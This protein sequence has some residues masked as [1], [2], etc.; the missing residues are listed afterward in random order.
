M[1]DVVQI[2]THQI[3]VA[4]RI[5]VVDQDW[6]EGLAVSI[7]V[8]GLMSPILVAQPKKGRSTYALIAGAHR[9]AAVRLLGW[10]EVPALV[11]AGSALEARLREIDENLIRRELSPLDRAAHLAERKRI[12]EELAP[13]TKH[14]GDRRS[15]QVANLATWSER[16]T[17]DAAR[18]LGVSE[19][20]VQRA[21]SRYTK[22]APDVRVGIS[23]TWLAHKGA[24]LDALARLAPDAQRAAVHLLLSE[25]DD[26]PRTVSAADKR[27]R[28]WVPSAPNAEDVAF[29]ALMKAWQKAPKRA[30]T[31]FVDA[32]VAQGDLAE[33]L[34]AA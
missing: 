10:T 5:R 19:R 9:L 12:Y 20:D 24:E 31:R 2:A 3:E 22:I 21:V 32:L 29:S 6:V 34:V 7:E 8:N 25:D 30:R 23:G 13:A 14:G 1:P 16:F 33:G 18:K 4:E 26:R 11:F 28:G 27:A 17:A 15:D